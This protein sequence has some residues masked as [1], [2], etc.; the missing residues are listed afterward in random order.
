MTVESEPHISQPIPELTT[1]DTYYEDMTDRNIGIMLP[2]EQ[3]TISRMLVAQAGVGG[4][5]DVT[6]TLA[7][8]GFQRFRIPIPTDRRCRPAACRWGRR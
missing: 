5:A 3:E 7:Q 1:W 8:M 6:I 4:N 2:E